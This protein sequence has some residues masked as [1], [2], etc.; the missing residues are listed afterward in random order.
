VKT[1]DFDK[2]EAELTAAF[3]IHKDCG[4]ALSGVHFELTGDNVTECVGGAEGLKA[5][6]LGRSYETY[7]DPRLNYAQSIE[8]AF[9][10]CS[11]LGFKNQSPIASKP[12]WNG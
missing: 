6:D 5:K 2:I 12:H 8:M 9:L 7:C 4:S 11:M 1:R 10:I 3:Q